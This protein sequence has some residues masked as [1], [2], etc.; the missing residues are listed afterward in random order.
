M[1]FIPTI[2][3][4][5][6]ISDAERDLLVLPVHLGGLGIIK[7]TIH[8]TIEYSCSKKL[9]YKLVILILSQN[10]YNHTTFMP[11]IKVQAT[12]KQEALTVATALLLSPPLLRSMQLCSGLSYQLYHKVPWFFFAQRGIS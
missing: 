10:Q 11:K 7:P 8:A 9:T 12:M 2:T 3:G 6:S 4:R 5:S 1:S